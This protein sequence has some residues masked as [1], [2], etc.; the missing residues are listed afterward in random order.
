[1][2]E[3]DPETNKPDL[4]ERAMRRQKRE[5]TA[6]VL[7]FFGVLLLVSPILNTILDLDHIFGIPAPVFYIFFVWVF[8]I[9][10]A[11]RLARSLKDD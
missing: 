6:L 10:F 3:P 8:L 7:P 5:D 2:S 1:M 9:F 11:G 4:A